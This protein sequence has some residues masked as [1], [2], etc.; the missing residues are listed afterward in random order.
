MNN[1]RIA[2]GQLEYI[3]LDAPPQAVRWLGEPQARMEGSKHS[4]CWFVST[5]LLFTSRSQLVEAVEAG[6]V[7]SIGISNYGVHHLD[8]LEHHIHEL[9]AERGGKGEGKGGILSVNQV[10]MHPW[11][12]RSDTVDW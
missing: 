4:P 8:E 2:V 7:R 6:K 10:K 3:K 9:E 11:C 1:C 5:Q 12:A